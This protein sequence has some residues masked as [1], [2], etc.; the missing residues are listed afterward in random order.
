VRLRDEL[1]RLATRARRPVDAI[2]MRMRAPIH[3]GLVTFLGDVFVYF[4]QREQHRRAIA[5]V[6]TADL[7][8]AAANKRK[9]GEPFIVVAHSMGGIIMYDLLTSALSNLEVDVL[10]TVGSQVAVI[11]ELKLF[12]SSDPAVPNASR[13]KVQKPRNVRRWVNVFDTTDILGFAASGV[14]ED[15]SDYEFATGHAWAHGGYFV[16]P[17]FHRRLGAR[18]Q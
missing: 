16:E 4:H 11:E 14:F 6:I 1:R 18:L 13:N 7:N 8:L 5:D 9:T 12:E 2:F 10:V 15:V 3:R 17:M